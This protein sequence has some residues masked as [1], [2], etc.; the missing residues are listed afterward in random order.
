MLELIMLDQSGM[1][2]RLFFKKKV[3]LF[4]LETQ[5]N[6]GGESRERRLLP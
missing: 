3:R 6:I 2:V 1:G 5:E 4:A